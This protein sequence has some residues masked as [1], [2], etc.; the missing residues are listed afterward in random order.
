MCMRAPRGLAPS[1]Y[2]THFYSGLGLARV[3]TELRVL[4]KS[5]V[6]HLINGHC[7]LKQ[8]VGERV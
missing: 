6:L 8:E 2:N 3:R 5:L 7:E 1:T 4:G